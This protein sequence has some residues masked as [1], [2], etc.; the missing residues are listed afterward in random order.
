MIKR[1][2]IGIDFD[3]CIDI[4]PES[5]KF[6]ADHLLHSG[7]EVHVITGRRLETDLDITVNA[8]KRLKFR[9]TEL[10]MYP[11]NY[12]LVLPLPM[13]ITQ[14]IGE[15]KSAICEDLGINL[16]WDDGLHRYRTEFTCPV[17]HV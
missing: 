13:D 4:K 15:W 2:A 3:G 17:V 11:G 16:F 5:F 7:H 14:A 9:Y 8:L 6:I 12:E 10:H 1:F